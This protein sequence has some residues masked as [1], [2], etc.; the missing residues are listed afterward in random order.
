M[1]PERKQIQRLISSM[2]YGVF[3]HG[4]SFKLDNTLGLSCQHLWGLKKLL[5]KKN[6]EPHFLLQATRMH[7]I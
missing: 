3:D 4:V 5:N 2:A 1:L 7:V 6:Y